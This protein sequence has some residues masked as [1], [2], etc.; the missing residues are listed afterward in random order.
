MTTLPSG[1]TNRAV[2]QETTDP[3]EHELSDPTQVIGSY[4]RELTAQLA[5]MQREYGDDI[6]RYGLEG[7]EEERA[8]A[9]HERIRF[10]TSTNPEHRRDAQSLELVGKA[11]ELAGVEE[12]EVEEAEM[13]KVIDASPEAFDLA[14]TG[15][16]VPEMENLVDHIASADAAITRGHAAT[17]LEAALP[18]AQ[19]YQP[20]LT[21]DALSP[22]EA[23][24]VVRELEQ[25]GNPRPI[26]L[27]KII[28]VWS[29]VAAAPEDRATLYAGHARAVLL[30]LDIT[31]WL[32]A[33]GHAPATHL[34]GPDWAEE[35]RA[36]FELRDRYTG[37]RE[38][39]AQEAIAGYTERHELMTAVLHSGATP[40]RVAAIHRERTDDH[41]RLNEISQAM[42]VGG[43]TEAQDDVAFADAARITAKWTGLDPT[44]E[45]LAARVDEIFA[46][47]RSRTGL[48]VQ[49]VMAYAER[50]ASVGFSYGPMEEARGA[51]EAT[52][53]EIL[54][55]Q[56][57]LDPDTVRAHA[58]ELQSTLDAAR[59][60]GR[61][62]WAE[63]SPSFGGVE[64]TRP[65]SI[66]GNGQNSSMVSPSRTLDSR[67]QEIAVALIDRYSSVLGTKT[68]PLLEA[69]KVRDVEALGM[70][71]RD[72]VDPTQVR[73]GS[74]FAESLRADLA[75]LLN[76]Q[77]GISVPK[78]LEQHD[79]VAARV[80]PSFSPKPF[81]ADV[82][83]EKLVS[84]S[85]QLKS[86]M[87]L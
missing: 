61:T 55:G 57:V 72:A 67:E 21:V 14:M 50:T 78:L 48:T 25:D 83:S 71:G 24:R 43:P 59:H 56:H 6:G 27:E 30:Q 31:R 76:G 11:M 29:T 45:N 3:R 15:T 60:K 44:I 68:E 65:T 79:N 64:Q 63:W 22:K 70:R 81:T 8:Y 54:T 37:L 28:N 86:P 77:L 12:S 23:H 47:N 87:S 53:I 5:Q 51:L 32:A 82:G 74:Q 9:L 36:G 84:E 40:E 16:R 35:V 17:F 41:A 20:D 10:L 2:R 13:W 62:Q 39:V 1:E 26:F 33:T 58:G 75:H 49:S 69:V 42:R 46:E 19:V 85:A 73:T 52:S 7:P 4:V 34:H 38:V 80:E 66:L 18:L